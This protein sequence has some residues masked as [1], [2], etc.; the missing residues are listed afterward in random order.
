MIHKI[1]RR[2][3]VNFRQSPSDRKGSLSYRNYHRQLGHL[4]KNVPM[5]SKIKFGRKGKK[6]KYDKS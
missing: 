5:I 3:R 2:V 4:I 6:E 1:L